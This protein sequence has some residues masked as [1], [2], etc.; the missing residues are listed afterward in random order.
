LRSVFLTLA[1]RQKDNLELILSDGAVYPLKGKLDIVGREVEA[2][3]GTL[4]LRGVFAN[5]AGILRPGQY[6]R[7]RAA[8]RIEK[9]ALLVPQRAVQEEQGEYEVAVLGADNH[10]AFRKV[11]ATDRVGSYWVIQQG[12]KPDDRVVVEGLQ[13]VKEGDTVDPKPATLP[14]L[15]ADLA[16]TS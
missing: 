4:R 2:S 11:R 12:L 16:G 5:P 6:S 8:T 1:D 15:P 7:I 14:P 3:T 13:K 10:V 9:D